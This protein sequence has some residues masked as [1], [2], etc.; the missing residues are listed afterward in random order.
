MKSNDEHDSGDISESLQVLD[1]KGE[2][3]KY[4]LTRTALI[5]PDGVT[6]DVVGK[7]LK[8]FKT[9]GDSIRFW[10]GDLLVYA[11]RNF[12]EMYAQLVDE[13]DF[14]FKSLQ[15][16]M[17]V[18][19]QVAPHVRSNTLSWSHHREVAKLEMAKQEE[20]LTRAATENMSVLALHK[21]IEGKDRRKTASRHDIADAYSV[22]LGAILRMA[23]ESALFNKELFNDAFP[24][25]CQIE[26]PSL[27]VTK[28]AILA[29]D[30]LKA[31]ASH[32]D[33][34]KR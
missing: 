20:W 31:Y 18:S 8:G 25:E 6:M 1:S 16:M 4:C 11:E 14:A 12:G 28:I 17:W 26:T 7:M 19:R 21:A 24:E 22:A 13:S 3:V 2:L 10:L 33:S 30:A 34:R 5:M 27:L 23:K 9:V 29:S 32:G 15:D